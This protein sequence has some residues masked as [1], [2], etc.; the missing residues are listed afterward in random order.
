MA[1]SHCVSVQTGRD[2]LEQVR[3]TA[4]RTGLSMGQVLSILVNEGVRMRRCPGIIF[5][6]GPTGRRASIAGSG[7]DV[8]EVIQVSK[9]CK[10][11]RQLAQAL[12]QLSARQI[13]A[14]LSYYAC[15][16][17]E[18]DRRIKENEV[19]PTTLQRR[20]PFIRKVRV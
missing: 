4:R 16:Q 10:D 8:W 14:A 11:R 19:S 20:S 6:D 18:L 17:G 2:V 1:K 15:F 12:P 13:D 3:E 5:A 9:A 7:I